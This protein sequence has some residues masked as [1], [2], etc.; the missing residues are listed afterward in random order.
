MI[1]SR[2]D[3]KAPSKT[4]DKIQ[5]IK[6]ESLV[7]PLLLS[8]VFFACLLLALPAQAKVDFNRDIRPIVSNTCFLCHGPDES[9]R[10]AKLRLDVR[11]DAIAHGAIVPGKPEESEAYKRVASKD[12]DDIM[13]PVEL[14]KA[15]TPQQI[16]TFRQWIA[17]GAEYKKH[18]SY[19]K[20]QRPNLPTV[21]NTKWPQNAVD[22]FILARLEKEN[23][24]PQPEA[25]KTSLDSSRFIGFNRPAANATRS[26][27]L[28]Y[29]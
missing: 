24:P 1:F 22:N 6:G 27:F 9:S 2:K 10:K 28:R 15:L 8:P 7:S 12:P 14:H 17:E 25:E 23:L 13:P 20:P 26:K 5:E 19:E 18:W 21:K 29:R 16:E 11:E 3:A 4:G